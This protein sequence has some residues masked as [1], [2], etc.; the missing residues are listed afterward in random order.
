M[1]KGTMTEVLIEGVREH[2]AVQAWLQVQSDP[3]EPGSLEVLQRRRYST[4]YRLSQAEQ[5]AARVI[6]K[7]CR[8]ATAR[9]EYTIYQTILPLTG[10]P[11]LHCYGVVEESEGE[12]CWLFLE[13]AA[14]VRYSP[15]LS[16]HREL[17]ACW[18]AK[19]Q[20]AAASTGLE[21]CLPARELDHYLGLL[22]GSRNTLLYHLAGSALPVE[23]GTVFRRV[24]AHIDL[25]E[26]LWKEIERIC[27][28]V[29]RTLV[30][31]DFV[32]KNLRIR[33]TATSPALLVFDWE[34]AGWGVPAAD[35]AQFTDRAA[36]PDLSLYWSTLNREHAG[37]DLR[38]IQ[39]V[40][41][42]GNLLRLVDQVSWATTGQESVPP[43]HLVKAAALLRSYEAS[44]V[45]ALNTFQRSRT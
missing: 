5:D 9:I 23:D 14:G 28:L 35:L 33:E 7:R 3:W 37:L 40:A 42:C 2:R 13:D 30:H 34:F 11:A 24:A 43:E 20:L 15:Q 4:V 22:R 29:P 26:S 12:F 41:A 31:G 39:A 21:A 6:A 25:I 1:S 16:Q 27:D 38:G 17:A 18:L 19:T 32:N 44:I 36:S 10:L 45:G 8:T